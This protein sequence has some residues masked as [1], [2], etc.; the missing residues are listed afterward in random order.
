MAKANEKSVREKLDEFLHEK[1]CVTDGL[2]FIESKT[3][4]NRLYLCLGK[5]NFP[6][7]FLG[8]FIAYLLVLL[9]F[10]SFSFVLIGKY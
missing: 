6:T 2:A 3:G 4:V 8:P 5:K 9:L 7:C 1:N 10:D